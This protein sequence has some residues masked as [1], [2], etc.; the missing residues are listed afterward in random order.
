MNTLFP[1]TLLCIIALVSFHANAQEVT[2]AF[3]PTSPTTG[4][5]IRLRLDVIGCI[6]TDGMSAEVLASEQA[7]EARI[8]FNDVACDPDDPS[9]V[10][11]QFIE[12]GKAPAAVY[13]TRIFGCI[14]SAP[15]PGGDP[16]TCN[17]VQ[18]G[19]LVVRGVS[20]MPATVPAA[21]NFGL[22]ALVL[23]V[24][25]GGAQIIRRR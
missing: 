11:P 6:S 25:F 16:I 3:E 24:V 1:A 23:T 10:T 8:L 13:S 14:L 9:N 18:G 19:I 22:L 15:A 4:D 20:S 7:I 2:Y 21:S 5:T 12:V 17:L